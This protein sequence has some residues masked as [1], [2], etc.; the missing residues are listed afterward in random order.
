[1]SEPIAVGHEVFMLAWVSHRGIFGASAKLKSDCCYLVNSKAGDIFRKF[2]VKF[3]LI[4]G[5]NI[6]IFSN[7]D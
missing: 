7:V 6:S 5:F 3:T 4:S 2:K 1:M